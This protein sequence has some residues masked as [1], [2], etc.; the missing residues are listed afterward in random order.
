MGLF[1][2]FR[3]DSDRDRAGRRAHHRR[4]Q[5][6]RIGRPFLR[7]QGRERAG[8][9]E[10]LPMITT[11][12]EQQLPQLNIVREASVMRRIFEDAMPRQQ[13]R[14]CVALNVRYKP[15]KS[16]LVAYRRA[17]GRD[18]MAPDG[19]APDGAAAPASQIVSARFYPPG[20]S[21]SR[22]V[23]APRGKLAAP[24]FGEAIFHVPDLDAVVWAFP[25]DRKLPG[26]P[27]LIDRDRV[28]R[29]VAPL[30][31]SRAAGR[32]IGSGRVS[33]EVIRYIPEH[34]CTVRVTAHPDDGGSPMVFYGKAYSDQSGEATW[35]N[36]SRLWDSARPEGGLG[37][38]A[39][40]A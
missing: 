11:P 31:A 34:G 27:A 36:M 23:K 32:R 18:G 6:R 22:F 10:V 9:F 12:A 24:K 3:R 1:R 35:R 5:L 15:G 26:V 25:N 16:G 19:M 2:W 39:R 14:D 17:M 4:T 37:N 21:L 38:S 30:L 8:H 20:S 13:I 28:A 33:L 40:P 29:E 7:A